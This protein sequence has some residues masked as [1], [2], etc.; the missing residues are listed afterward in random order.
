MNETDLAD[1]EFLVTD[2]GWQ[3]SRGYNNDEAIYFSTPPP[4]EGWEEL[5]TAAP[6]PDGNPRTLW[7]RPR[8]PAAIPDSDVSQMG[9]LDMPE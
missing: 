5:G 9:Q 7:W 3:V 8:P 6:G 1:E 2:D 4:G